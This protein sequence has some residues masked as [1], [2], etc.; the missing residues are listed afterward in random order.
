MKNPIRLRSFLVAFAVLMMLSCSGARYAN[1]GTASDRTG[2]NGATN[3]N[4]KT[5]TDNT[6]NFK[7]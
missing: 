7:Y 4:G 5:P 6:H 1:S 2:T 3:G